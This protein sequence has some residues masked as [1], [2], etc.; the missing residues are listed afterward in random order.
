[1]ECWIFFIIV[2]YPAEIA[3]NQIEIGI[4]RDLVETELEREKV[5]TTIEI[6]MTVNET[7]TG[8][9]TTARRWKAVR[10]TERGGRERATEVG[11]EGGGE[12]MTTEERG[13]VPAM[14]GEGRE[15]KEVGGQEG[16]AEDT[17]SS[18]T[19]PY[20]NNIILPTG[21]KVLVEGILTIFFKIF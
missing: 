1:M 15:V 16:V 11:E 14:V 8:G 21:C 10:E 4:A 2:F 17:V 13:V 12:E 5:E 9:T 7:E 19:M 20:Y 18:S 3:T 6:A